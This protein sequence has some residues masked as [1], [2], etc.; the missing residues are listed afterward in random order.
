VDNAM[1]HHHSSCFHH[2]FYGGDRPSGFA[3]IVASPEQT[4]L[5]LLLSPGR[6]L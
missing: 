3:T 4:N 2:R 6:S 1:V 5:C